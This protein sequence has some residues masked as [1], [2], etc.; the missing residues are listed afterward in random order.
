MSNSPW[1][2]KFRS[3]QYQPIQCQPIVWLWLILLSL[4]ISSELPATA[5]TATN[6]AIGTTVQQPNVKHFGITM[7][8]ENFYDSAQ[9]L[10][11]LLYRN[12]QALKRRDLAIRAELCRGDGPTTCTDKNIWGVWPANFLAGREFPSSSTEQP[13]GRRERSPSNTASNLRRAMPPIHPHGMTLSSAVAG[14][15]TGRGRLSGRQNECAWKC[16]GRLANE[17]LRV[18]RPLSTDTTDIAPDSPGKQ[19]LMISAAASG[20]S[21][22]RQ[23]PKAFDTT[24][25]RSFVQMKGPYTFDF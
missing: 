10:R 13:T 23:S 12:P 16:A 6:F 20:Q 15:S 22:Q 25:G 5:Q 19:A 3:L 24:G 1:T 8:D 18:E 2:R 4:F 9:M 11:N 7:G 17:H 14:D 21:A